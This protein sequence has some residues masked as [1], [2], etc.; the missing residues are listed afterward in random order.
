MSL[1]KHYEEIDNLDMGSRKSSKK[2]TPNDAVGDEFTN[3]LDELVESLDENVGK[4]NVIKGNEI[5]SALAKF[6]KSEIMRL[7]ESM[8]ALEN[9]KK[10][11]KSWDSQYPKPQRLTDYLVEIGKVQELSNFS[12]NEVVAITFMSDCYIEYREKWNDPDKELTAEELLSRLIQKS[13]ERDAFPPDLFQWGGLSDLG[14]Y[15]TIF[16]TGYKNHAESMESSWSY[17][18]SELMESKNATLKRIKAEQDL[19]RNLRSKS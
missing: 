8:L 16:P 9:N 4:P 1:Y 15:E 2:N 13:L 12:E 17:H 5:S 10:V 3:E 7:G 6:S 11:L 19:A 18:Y 14:S